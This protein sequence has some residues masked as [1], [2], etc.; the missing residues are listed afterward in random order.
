MKKF[1]EL[2]ERLNVKN[3]NVS[4]HTIKDPIIGKIAYDYNG[5]P[6]EI[7]DFCKFADKYKL[8][9]LII[10]YD[11]NGVFKDFLEEYD[12]KYYETI[13]YVVAVESPFNPEFT[14]FVWGH[15]GLCFENKP[16]ENK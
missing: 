8:R 9:K 6:W 1:T 5:D 12:P 3:L 11:S 14:I 15:D 16:K 4:I 2:L 7:I 10:K 13:G